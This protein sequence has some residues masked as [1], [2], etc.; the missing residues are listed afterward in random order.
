MSD[1]HRWL[2]TMIAREMNR[3]A[4]WILLA[5]AGVTLT[6]CTPAP[7]DE[8]ILHGPSY[9]FHAE[10]GYNNE[11][12][13]IGYRLDNNVVAGVYHNSLY[14]PSA[15]VGY[16]VELHQRV[17]ILVGAVTG[18]ERRPIWPAALLTIN[19]PL[20]NRWRLHVNVAPIAD[21]FI[22]VALGYQLEKAK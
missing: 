2:A 6:H 3:V 14:N 19:A 11:N 8:L 12:Y 17:G 4:F 9:H 1:L 5:I 16:V 20:G 13:G 15:Y 10:R 18:Y 22:N 21:G 7:A